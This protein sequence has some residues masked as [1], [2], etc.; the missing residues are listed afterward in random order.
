MAK[1]SSTTKVSPEVRAL[2]PSFGPRRASGT[3]LPRAP[4]PL[5]VSDP[6]AMGRASRDVIAPILERRLGPA[7]AQA[8][9]Q[10]LGRPGATIEGVLNGLATTGGM[11]VGKE[12]AGLQQEINAARSGIAPTPSVGTSAREGAIQGAAAGI[13]G[14]PIGMGIGA[15][16]GAVGGVVGGRAASRKREDQR[17]HLEN[18]RGLATADAFGNEVT[19]LESGVREAAL[20]SGAGAR[21]A[22][23]LE[24]AITASGLR[25]TGIGTLASIAAGVQVPLEG[26]MATFS[27]AMGEIQKNVGV[28]LGEPVGATRPDPLARALEGM[29]TLFLTPGATSF[30]PQRAQ[31]VPENTGFET[32]PIFPVAKSEDT[33]NLF[34]PGGV[35]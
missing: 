33:G 15:I 17:R 21:R 11:D 23:D 32:P 7:L 22:Q 19:K 4:R 3:R 5:A 6:V 10:Q 31:R 1:T 27:A 8:V 35:F 20:A 13:G 18:A 28:A 26:I 2:F 16:A 24:A 14:G 30:N 34:G 9:G 12:L 25:D 29:A